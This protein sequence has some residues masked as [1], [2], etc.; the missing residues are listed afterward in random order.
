MHLTSAWLGYDLPYDTIEAHPQV[1]QWRAAGVEKRIKRPEHHLT[2]GFFESVDVDA[3][4]SILKEFQAIEKIALTFDG[5]GELNG[6]I[7]LT[8]DSV[9]AP[10]TLRKHL[11]DS[12]ILKENKDFHVSIGGP[13]SF[14]DQKSRQQDFT[15]PLSVEGRLV[16]VGKSGND[17]KRLTWSDE[18]SLFIDEDQPAQITDAIPVHTIAM[19]PK[20]QADT[21]TA[22]Y[23]LARFGKDKFSGI[24][25]AQV[26]FWTAL[27]EGETAE[28]L[29]KKGTLTI[30]LGGRFDHHLANQA[31]GK[32][33]ETASSLVA[34]YLGLVDQK[35][36]QKILAWAKRDDLEGK[37]TI[38]VDPL[39]RAFGLSGLMMNL[40]RFFA[41]N[42]KKVLDYI[43]PLLH[44][45]V[46]E[47]QKRA[48]ELPKEWEVLQASGDGSVFKLKQGSADLKTAF[49]KSENIALPGFLR[50]AK[51]MDM[52]IQRRIS[53]HTNIITRQE[54]SIDLRPLIEALRKAEATKKQISLDVSQNELQKVGS[55]KQV[56]EWYYDDAA[57]TLQNGG[58]SPGD[59][60]ATRLS[61]EEILTLVK[62]KI[63]LG[64]IGSLKR[65]KTQGR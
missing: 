54:R 46:L 19:F 53:G 9:S 4:A 65:K 47:E 33:E 52:I 51:R 58:V 22:A 42:P 50:A 32:R 5:Y 15:P 60:P 43:L 34:K 3:L 56:P 13:D 23:L 39:D 8:P 59:V 35:A 17:F 28:S 55:I 11:L 30:D 2:V 26:V 12:G 38:S 41:D 27:P 45:H 6:Y 61:A 57:N 18:Q 21:A 20:I 24:D 1:K 10:L 44:Y 64:I 25:T 49:V 36:F 29:L 48:D 16:L 37:G 40:N 63:P 62:E 7:Y 14:S 31:S